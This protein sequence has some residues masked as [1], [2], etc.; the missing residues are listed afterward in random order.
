MQS[1]GG[2]SPP[3]PSPGLRGE[4]ELLLQGTKSK[5]NSNF[6]LLEKSH[7]QSQRKNWRRLWVE[8]C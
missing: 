4:S 2:D 8:A 6:S 5:E 1:D 3:T 7:A